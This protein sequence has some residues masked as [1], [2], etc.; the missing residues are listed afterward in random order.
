M[1]QGDKGDQEEVVVQGDE[2]DQED[3]EDHGNE[4]DQEDFVDQGAM[5][6]SFRRTGLIKGTRVIR[7]TSGSGGRG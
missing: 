1:D 6:I 5:V 3:V 4:S 2:G 7:R